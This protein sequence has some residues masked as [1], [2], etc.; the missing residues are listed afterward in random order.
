MLKTGRRVLSAS[1]LFNTWRFP[2]TYLEYTSVGVRK[3]NIF[4]PT[5]IQSAVR[6]LYVNVDCSRLSG[7]VR[8]TSG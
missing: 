6:A 2:N 7:D 5:M 1:T 3:R 4:V 8:R